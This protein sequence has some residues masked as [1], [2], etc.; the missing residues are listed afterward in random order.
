VFEPIN[1]SPGESTDRTSSRRESGWD[2]LKWLVAGAFISACFF[3]A[4]EVFLAKGGFTLSVPNAQY[5]PAATAPAAGTIGPTNQPTPLVDHQGQGSQ[6]LAS[7]HLVATEVV[8]RNSPRGITFNVPAS[9]TYEFR[10]I[11]GAYSTYRSGAAPAG[12]A[13]WIASVCVFGGSPVWHGNILSTSDASLVIGWG[14]QYFG[15]QSEAA[16]A[17]SGQAFDTALNAGDR[18]TLVTVD[19]QDAYPDNAGSD[20]TIEIWQIA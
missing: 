9:G 6:P 17:A 10:Y 11:S 7:A 1:G 14:D 4:A 15:S 12:K 5:A 8:P 3:V 20:I 18:L 2:R 16:S 19:A 13:T